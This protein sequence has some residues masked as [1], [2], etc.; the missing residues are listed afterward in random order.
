MEPTKDPK[1]TYLGDGLYASYDGYQIEL[2][3]YDGIS[4]TN[5][6]FLEPAVLQ[7]FEEYVEKLRSTI[8]AG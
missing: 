6:V 2:Y 7:A 3:A 8:E 4:K 5:I 1:D